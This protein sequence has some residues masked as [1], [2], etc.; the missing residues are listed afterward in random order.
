MLVLFDF[1]EVLGLPQTPADRRNLATYSG[2]DLATLEQ[3]YWADR[4]AYDSGDL[5]DADYWSAVAGR[6][7]THGLVAHLTDLDTASWLRLCP[8]VVA[9]HADLLADGV[10]TALF[11]NAP[12]AIADA[13]DTLPELSG[14]RGRFFSARLRLA[15][16]DAAAFAAVLDALGREPGDVVFVDDRIVNVEGARDAGLHAVHFTGAASLRR[17]L[18]R[19]LIR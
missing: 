16:P 4:H 19:M 3:R 12:T 9:V 5:S 15:K 18:D 7:L 14:M 2:I 8:D 13:I 11:S 6:D 1:G 10:P 17:E